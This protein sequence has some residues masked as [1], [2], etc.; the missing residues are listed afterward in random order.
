MAYWKDLFCGSV[1]APLAPVQPLS[2]KE[3]ADDESLLAGSPESPALA[4][5]L[6]AVYLSTDKN[7]NLRKLNEL[8]AAVDWPQRSLRRVELAL[9]HSYLVVSMWQVHKDSRRLVGFCRATSDHVFNATIWDM[10]ILPEAQRAGLGRTLMR[11]SINTLRQRNIGLI[12]AF[13]E[14]HAIGFYRDLGFTPD[15]DGAVGLVCNQYD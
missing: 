4:P 10:A 5:D 7:F 11:F 13:A 1:G 12:T 3:S 15:V 6:A 14:P 2:S 8:W 9:E